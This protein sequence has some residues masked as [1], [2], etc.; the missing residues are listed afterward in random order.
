MVAHHRRPLA[1]F[2]PVPLPVCTGV[3][4]YI[5]K[6]NVIGYNEFTQLMKGLQGERLRQAFAHFDPSGTGQIS[7]DEFKRIIIEIARHKLSDSVLE[8]LPTLCLL[9]P[10]Q[11]V[12]YSEARAFLNV[13]R[14][15]DLVERV[16]RD[17]QSAP[18]LGVMLRLDG[19]PI[20]FAL[21]IPCD[22]AVNASKDGKIDVD[23]F[24]NTACTYPL[25]LPS[26]LTFNSIAIETLG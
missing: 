7:P 14:D 25:C 8:R 23:D 22:A 19:W 20:A 12:S 16:I 17:G 6:K 13:L 11:R 3:K 2:P 4:L 18:F 24:L 15:M 9:S 10:G 26:L 21:Y 1:S 5:G